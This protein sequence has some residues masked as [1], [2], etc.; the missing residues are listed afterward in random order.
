MSRQKSKT[1]VPEELEDFKANEESSEGSGEVDNG[2]TTPKGDDHVH[3]VAKGNGEA[4]PTSKGKRE[5]IKAKDSKHERHE[6][7]PAKLAG[8]FKKVLPDRGAISHSINLLL[9]RG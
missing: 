2:E 4:S 3:A 8:T 1:A 5:K 9:L 7:M 6:K